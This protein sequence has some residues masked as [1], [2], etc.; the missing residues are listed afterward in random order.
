M[1]LDQSESFGVLN[2]D[3]EAAEHLLLVSELR[4]VQKVEAGVGDRERLEIQN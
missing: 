3:S 4:K 2:G 1:I